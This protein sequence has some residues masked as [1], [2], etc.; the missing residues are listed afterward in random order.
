MNIPDYVGR[1]LNNVLDEIKKYEDSYKIIIKE[2]I[3]PANKDTVENTECRIVRQ[4][5]SDNTIEI[6]VSYF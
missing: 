2:T 4:K 5:V 6:T 3:S 1:K